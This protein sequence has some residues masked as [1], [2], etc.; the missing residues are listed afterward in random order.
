MNTN[1]VRQCTE[2]LLVSFMHA[3]STH[4][5]MYTASTNV[6]NTT[7]TYINMTSRVQP[8]RIRLEATQGLTGYQVPNLAQKHL[9][10]LTNKLIPNTQIW[11]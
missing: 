4:T 8:P 9:V 5:H 6:F 2:R 3:I 1:T 11:F 10:D 7:P